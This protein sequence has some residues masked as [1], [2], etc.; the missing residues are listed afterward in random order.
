MNTL[1]K[2]DL[3]SLSNEESAKAVICPEWKHWRSI[4]RQTQSMPLLIVRHLSRKGEFLLA[5]KWAQIHEVPDPIYLVS[6]NTKFV[7]DF[8]ENNIC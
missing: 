6:I 1:S 8:V 4:K 7:V 5:K 3:N 2:P